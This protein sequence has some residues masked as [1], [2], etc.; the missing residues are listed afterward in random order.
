MI[1]KLK[2]KNFILIKIFNKDIEIYSNN[3]CYVD[4]DEESYDEKC[5]VFFYFLGLE[6]SLL[7]YKK[8]FF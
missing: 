3:F 5:F 1:L 6:S 2:N 7:K 8:F 4:S